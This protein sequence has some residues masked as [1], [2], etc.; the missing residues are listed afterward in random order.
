MTKKFYNSASV[1]RLKE[2]EDVMGRKAIKVL[3]E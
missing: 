3:D 2:N 1:K